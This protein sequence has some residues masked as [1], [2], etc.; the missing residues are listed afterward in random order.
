MD[1]NVTPITP[2]NAAAERAAAAVQGGAMSRFAAMPARAKMMLALGIAGLLAVLVSMFLW[3]GNGNLAPL[4]PNLSE[5]DAGAVIS[6]LTAL[7][8]PYKAAGDGTTLMVPAEMIPELR[9][10]LAQAGLPKGTTAGF[11]LMDNARFGQSQL[12]ERTNLQRALEGEL[13]RSITSISA[14]QSARVHLALP[15]Q[16]GFFREQQKPSASVLLTLHPGRTLDRAQVAGIVHLVSSSVPELSTKSV[17]VV[18]QTSTLLSAPPEANQGL[19]THQLQYLQQVEASYLKRV[20]EILEPAMGRDNLRA[21]VTAEVDF[22]Q[23]ESTT[24]E[25]KPN[26]TGEATIRSQRQS[27]ASNAST[28]TPSGVPGAASNQPPQGAAAPLAGASAPLQAA[29]MGSAGG[30]ARKENTVNYEV[31]KTVSMKRQAVGTIKRIN[32]AVLVNHRSTTDPKGKVT[33]TPLSQDELDKLT[34]L[35][36]ESIGF[37]KERGDS[38]KVVNIPFRVEAQPKTEEVPMWKQPWL[39]DLVRAGAVP[40]GLAFVALLLVFAVIRPALNQIEPPPAPAK[41]D[42][43]VDDAEKLPAPEEMPALTH[44]PSKADTQLEGARGLAR[45]NPAAVANIVRGWVSGEVA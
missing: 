11:E 12:Q 39:V 32:A 13:V 20:V 18:D 2:N 34:A 22:N 37:N 10:K 26:Q 27:E 9:L 30:G 45:Q 28:A 40:A 14:V 24:E 1:A 23:L 15:S 3:S 35:V 16:N 19:D 31:D 44:E 7:K 41:L 33:T 38:V 42:A 21:T 36:Q 25:F 17:S 5:K 8:V 43:V 29:Q 6:Q 4:Y